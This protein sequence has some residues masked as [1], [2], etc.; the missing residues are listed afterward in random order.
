MSSD[1]VVCTA[2]SAAGWL[3]PLL[4]RMRPWTVDWIAL[5]QPHLAIRPRL[6][7]WLSR[8]RT[9]SERTASSRSS[10]SVTMSSDT[11]VCV[12]PRL[13]TRLLR[14]RMTGRPPL[15]PLACATHYIHFHSCLEHSHNPLECLRHIGRASYVVVACPDDQMPSSWFS[16]A[17]D[18]I[19]ED[20]G[21]GVTIT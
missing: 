14:A 6:Q 13:R 17:P 16:G 10:G 11:V 19:S 18:R 15:A 7:P 1:I 8:A 9:A 4:R 20:G 2:T 5:G 21:N 12:P 3:H